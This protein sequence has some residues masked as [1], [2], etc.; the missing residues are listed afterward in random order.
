MARDYVSGTLFTS[1]IVAF[2]TFLGL[3]ISGV[4]SPLL[5]AIFCGI[6]N[7][8]PYFGPYIGAI[9][10]IIV[11]FTISPITGLCCVI[12]ILVVQL[13]ENNF[14]QPIIMGHT[15]KLHPVTIMLGLLIFQHFFGIIGMIVATPVIAA[16]KVIFTYIDEKL[17]IIGKL[18]GEDK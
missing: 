9:P 17:N 8:I 4:S 13:L 3:L 11:G 12:S 6:T 14:Y 1:L 15:M 7:I 5:F 2:L 10:A 18:T 16:G